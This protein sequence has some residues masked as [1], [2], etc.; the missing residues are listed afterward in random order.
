MWGSGT[1]ERVA[2]VAVV[3][4]DRPDVPANGHDSEPAGRYQSAAASRI[5]WWEESRVKEGVTSAVERSEGVE[6]KGGNG[7]V[8]LIIGQN[9]PE[10]P[11]TSPSTGSP[12]ARHGTSRSTVFG[13][14]SASSV[15]KAGGPGSPSPGPRGLCIGQTDCTTHSGNSI[16][17]LLAALTSGFHIDL[18]G[19]HFERYVHD[20]S[21][22]ISLSRM[23]DSNSSDD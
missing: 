15:G 4:E 3:D 21:R 5:A 14:P 23:L 22:P 17:R 7:S 18:C 16:A 10:G 1:T 13:L 9:R 6:R 11:R 20:R 2:S 8:P 12:T 19:F